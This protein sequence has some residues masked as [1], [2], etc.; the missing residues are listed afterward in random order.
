MVD[1][2]RIG[3]IR[4]GTSNGREYSVIDM[5]AGPN[6]DSHVLT[7]GESISEI[8]AVLDCGDAI[9]QRL[10]QAANRGGQRI[11][12]HDV[13]D[14]SQQQRDHDTLVA[15]YRATG[16]VSWNQD[17][18]WGTPV[19]I[20]EWYGVSSLPGETG[21]VT[22]LVLGRNN[23]TG[24]IP[25]EL[26][27]L[28]NLITLALA[29]NNLKGSIPAELGDLVNLKILD[30]LHNGLTGAIPAELGKLEDLEA[31]MLVGNELSG[32]IP[33]ELGNLTNL[34]DLHL[35][36][37]TGLCLAQGFPLKSQF[38]TMAQARGVVGC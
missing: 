29:N 15:F 9:A 28:P 12:I 8:C 32:A 17:D 34:I 35:D 21:N 4:G 5:L 16:G 7:V 20:G 19:P 13:S 11:A 25:A 33:V 14:E 26:G 3:E 36:T 38:G 18:H 30:L 31:L 6:V 2:C 10:A 1:T 22:A 24:E 37:D 23:L 27:S